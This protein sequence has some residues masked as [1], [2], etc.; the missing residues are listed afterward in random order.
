MKRFIAIFLPFLPTD[1][2]ARRAE[3]DGIPP[4]CPRA[5]FAST[6]GALRLAAVDARSRKAGLH[7]G[8]GLA[9]ARARC[10]DLVATRHDPDG[11]DAALKSLALWAQRWSPSIARVADGLLLDATGAAHLFG[12]EAEWLA[13]IPHELGRFGL[14]A[15]AGLADTIGAAWAAARYG[16]QAATRIAPGETRI[17][18]A[19]YPPAALRLPPDILGDLDRLGLRRIA[20]LEALVRASDPRRGLDAR[21][22]PEPLRRLRQAFGEI[23]E[24]LDP[25]IPVPAMRA[26]LA[27]A[28][29][30][31]TPEDIARIVER[32]ALELCAKLEAAEL[33][34][35][36]ARL[37]ALRVD[38]TAT[39]LALGTSKPMRDAK[40]LVRLF[41][42]HLPK[43][44]P[45]FGIDT[46]LLDAEIANP[47]SLR[48]SAIAL[49]DGD[50]DL[51][52]L[53][54]LVDRLINRLGAANV[55][56]LAPFESHIPERAQIRLPALGAVPAHLRN[57]KPPANPRPLRLLAWP[58]PI[59]ALAEL[60]DGPPRRFR[61]RK[62]LHDVVRAEGPERIAPEWWRAPAPPRDYFAIDD[63]DGHRF[64]V[65]REGA[66]GGLRWFLHGLFA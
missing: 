19:D 56:R 26:R 21:F 66:A 17:A 63:R 48:Q 38:G 29:P 6:A 3:R 46:A 36:R 51:G 55:V 23:D 33:G 28:E 37:I 8:L 20:D 9:E 60:P 32:L 50:P 24:P 27:F 45:G 4:H 1:R 14:Q 40:A 22:G 31:S 7:P 43:L 39:H 64:W 10:P 11:D 58:E 54:P 2:A 62:R 61:W 53:A 18:L 12:G 35:R 41:A 25:D 5:T 59:E 34:L 65:Y 47:L 42:E 52:E 44:D 15:R 16:A 49:P 30:V 13:A 57:A